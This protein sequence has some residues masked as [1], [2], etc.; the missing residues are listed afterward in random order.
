MPNPSTKRKAKDD[1]KEAW[2]AEHMRVNGVGREKAE[3]KYKSMKRHGLI[4]SGPVEVVFPG[5]ETLVYR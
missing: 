5:G 1:Q 3:K 4:D 2:I